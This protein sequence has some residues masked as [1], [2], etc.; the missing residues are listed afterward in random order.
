MR[1]GISI[2]LALSITSP[3]AQFIIPLT[4]SVVILS[5]IIQGLSFKWISNKL[6]PI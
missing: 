4:Y 3:A 5:I 1:G 6:F 2:A